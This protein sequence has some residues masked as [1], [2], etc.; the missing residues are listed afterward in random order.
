MGLKKIAF[1]IYDFVTF[2]I[3]RV[4]EPTLD[5]IEY[6]LAKYRTEKAESRSVSQQLNR[7]VV[8]AFNNIHA[9]PLL[10][11]GQPA[12]TKGRIALPVLSKAS[13]ERKPEW[14]GKDSFAKPA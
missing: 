12:G 14:R 2:K 3:S 8:K 13:K 1:E 6:R 4:L 10:K 5:E 7:P 9:E 11:L